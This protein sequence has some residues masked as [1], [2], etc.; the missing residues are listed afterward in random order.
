MALVN[1]LLWTIYVVTLPCKSAENQKQNQLII[2]EWTFVSEELLHHEKIHSTTAPPIKAGFKS[3]YVFSKDGICEDK[4]GYFNRLNRNYTQFLGTK[5]K[6]RLENNHLEIFDLAYKIWR[7]YQILKLDDKTLKLVLN[8]SVNAIYERSHYEL[9]PKVPFD[10]IIVSSS[11]CLG[12]CPINDVIIS[13]DEKV[14]F[15]NEGF[16]QREGVF[17]S[18]ITLS[19]F[20]EIE[21]RFR[22]TDLNKLKDKYAASWTDDNEITISLIQNGRIYKTISDYGSQSPSELYWAYLPVIFLDQKL[23][24]KSLSDNTNFYIRKIF[25]F[26]K[27]EKLIRLAQSEGFYLADLLQK[28]FL[29]IRFSSKNTLCRHLAS[30][31]RLKRRQMVVIIR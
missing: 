31:D 20:D 2:G 3:G 26:E 22:K 18:S 15:N 10:K 29:S 11:G 17:S 5:T 30:K 7:S 24:L 19:E 9:A 14:I 21:K 8:D 28:Q 25:S 12:S 23:I 4:L 1:Y 16:R 27:D 6:F 13:R